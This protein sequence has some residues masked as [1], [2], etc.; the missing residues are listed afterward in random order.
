MWMRSISAGNRPLEA[1]SDDDMVCGLDVCDELDELDKNSFSD[2]YVNDRGG[3]YTDEVTGVTL[4][5]DDVA[6][7]TNG[8]D[9]VA[10]KVPSPQ[11]SDR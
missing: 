3:D 10:R 7:S 4:L 1:G 5:R 11:R 8:T 9:E 6:K 2:T